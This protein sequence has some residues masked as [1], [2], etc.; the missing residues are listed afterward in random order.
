MAHPGMTRLAI[1][2]DDLSSA[3][4]CGA[5]MVRSGLSVVVPLKG[6]P[7]PVQARDAN[8]ISVDTDS[9]S[10]SADQAY[11]NV[12]A[13]TQQLLLEGRTAFYKSVDSTL[14]GNLGAEVEAVLDVVRPDCA[15]I[16]PAFP[17]YGRTTVDGIQYLHG[18][19]L[20]ETEFGT[21][22]T[23]PVKDADI[24]RRLA[25]GSRRRCGWLTLDRLRAGPEQS[26]QAVEG[27]VANGVELMVIDIV[28]QEDLRQLCLGLSH[29]NL[30]VAFVGSTGLAEFVPL[31]FSFNSISIGRNEEH[32]MD[33]RP[34][35]ALVGSASE[36]TRRQLQYAQTK[37]QLKIIRL[38]PTH[39]IQHGKTA[40][41]ELEKTEAILRASLASGHDAAFAVNSSRDEIV[42]TQQLGAR[43]NLSASQVAQR[44]VDWLA[45]VGSR[46]VSEGQISGI[47]ATGGDTANALCNALGAQALEILGEVEAGI[48]IMRL[49]GAQSLPLVT[50]AGGFGSSA[51]LADALVKVKQYA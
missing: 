30:K 21:D 34:A 11:V 16:A 50:K 6:Y 1:I 22:P 10:L 38:D 29:S 51:A 5:Q 13:A 28:E 32:S 2:A 15:I 36:T 3:T 44:I 37:N 19:P 7:L 14:R 8:V 48:P 47:V 25:E 27:M 12:R 49:L 41:A 18:R 9:R 43:L 35:L 40:A 24:G 20:H 39:V 45:Q 17:K 23:A 26:M 46:L 31:A 42:A 33:P 4:D